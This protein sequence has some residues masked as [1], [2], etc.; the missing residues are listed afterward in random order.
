MQSQDIRWILF[1]GLYS[2]LQAFKPIATAINNAMTGGDT[3][4]VYDYI[5]TASG[6]PLDSAC[7][8]DG[9]INPDALNPDAQHA[10]LCS[11]GA[12]ISGR[13]MTFWRGYVDKQLAQ[14]S[15]VGDIWPLNRISCSNWKTRA[16]WQFHGP[17]TTPEPSKLTSAPEPG[18]PAAP[19][20]FLSNRLD[21]VTPLGGAQKVAKKYPGASLL[22]QETMGHTAFGAHKF[23]NCTTDLVRQYMD[24]GVVPAKETS[25]EAA[26]DPWAAQC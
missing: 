7:A 19:I 15:L 2:P 22:I 20:F 9:H 17:F 23:T 12:D 21:P 8:G 5:A 14:S 16:K 24:E 26:C 3:A 13:N 6:G 25:C 10:I 4:A 11:D 1:N 18:R